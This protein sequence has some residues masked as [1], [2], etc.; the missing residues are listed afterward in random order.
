MNNHVEEIVIN[1]QEQIITMQSG[2]SNFVYIKSIEK[3][4]KCSV[5]DYFVLWS[6]DIGDNFHIINTSYKIVY[7][8]NN[9]NPHKGKIINIDNVHKN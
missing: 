1:E 5:D 2:S 7:K 9:M 4:L 3:N 6:M 8:W